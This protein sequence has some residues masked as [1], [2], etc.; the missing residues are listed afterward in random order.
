MPGEEDEKSLAVA[1][2]NHGRA[3]QRTERRV[4]YGRLTLYISGG[5]RSMAAGRLRYC[6]FW[7]K[8]E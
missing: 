1:T 7:S 8:N 5:V 3:T 6:D 2:T 4:C